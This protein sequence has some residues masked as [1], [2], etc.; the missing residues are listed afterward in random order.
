MHVNVEK[1][2]TKRIQSQYKGLCHQGGV[3]IQLL[4]NCKQGGR[5]KIVGHSSSL[6]VQTHFVRVDHI[7]GNESFGAALD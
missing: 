1:T 4:N 6:P 3:L 2:N 7:R 5:S